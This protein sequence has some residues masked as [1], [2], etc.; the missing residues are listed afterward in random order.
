MTGRA[1]KILIVEDHLLIARQLEAIVTDAGHDVVGT[2][3]DGPRACV[4]ADLTQP[5]LVFLD[6]RLAGAPSG[7]D[8]AMAI[9]KTCPAH[10][11]FTTAN[12]RR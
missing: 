8:V 3:L 11:V 5:D 6:V 7:L 1:L 12:R 4:L 10:V 2:A 9:A